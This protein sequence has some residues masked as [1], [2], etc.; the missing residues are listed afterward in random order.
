MGGG[1]TDGQMHCVY[2]QEVS[3]SARLSEGKRQK[4]RE[5]REAWLG[6]CWL[7][8]DLRLLGKGGGKRGDSGFLSFA[9]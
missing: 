5:Q 3:R 2:K 6:I 7:S 8:M 1:G 9:F 4:S